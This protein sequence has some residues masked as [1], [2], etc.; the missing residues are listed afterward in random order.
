MQK[1]AYALFPF[2]FLSLLKIILP[3]TVA[4]FMYQTYALRTEMP[5]PASIFDLGCW[6][7]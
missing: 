1:W 4:F 6:Y 2:I 5:L 7:L 3:L